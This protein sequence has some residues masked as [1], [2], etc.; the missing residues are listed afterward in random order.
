MI[1]NK[2]LVD[3]ARFISIDFDVWCDDLIFDLL[4]G[5]SFKE[6]RSGKRVSEYIK[7]TE[8]SVSLNEDKLIFSSGQTVKIHN[9]LLVSFT[10]YLS[11]D[12]E[13]WCDNFIYDYLIGRQVA[14][15]IAFNDAIDI[16]I[17]EFVGE[18]DI[19]SQPIQGTLF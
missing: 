15:S 14:Y 5:K 8:K 12:F 11:V 13:I 9:K 7:K 16:Y 19:Q 6:W 2:I 17:K 10:R 18:N 3:F 4:T 1:H